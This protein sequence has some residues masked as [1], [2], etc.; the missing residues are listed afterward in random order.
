MK[1]FRR[2]NASKH[3][4]NVAHLSEMV[5][6]ARRR[7]IYDQSTGFLAPWFMSLRL[8]E[9]CVRSERYG[10]PLAA[11]SLSAPADAIE[12]LNAWLT[13][14]F[15]GTDLIC[16]LSDARYVVLLPET[17]LDG[18][19]GVAKRVLAKFRVNGISVVEY[20]ADPDEFQKVVE[21][22]EEDSR[23]P[24]GLSA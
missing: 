18:A 13:K 12:E 22:I 1:L 19:S 9:E 7:A 2:A 3:L 11:V 10:R 15:R 24:S 21:L 6:G 20:S 8:S 16:K 5:E 23:T 14:A 4:A 17:G